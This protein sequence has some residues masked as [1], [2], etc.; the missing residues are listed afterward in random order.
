MLN[1]SVSLGRAGVPVSFIS[2]F[3]QDNVGNLIKD[4]LSI[5]G[6][7][8]AGLSLYN[9]KSPLSL[10]FLDERNDASYEFY[11]DF[12]EKR[13]G[14]N[15]PQFEPEDILVFGSIMSLDPET[16]QGLKN[17]LVSAKNSGTTLYYD[18]NFREVLSSSPEDIRSMI[19]ENIA[20]ADIV[21]ASDEDMRIIG[22]C[23]D[24]DEAYDFVCQRGCDILIYTANSRGVYLRTPSYSGDYTV[25]EI[26]AI[27]TVGAGDSFNAGIAYM[28]HKRKVKDLH[29]VAWWQWDEIIYTAIEFASHVCMSTDNY[30]S[31]EFADMLKK[32]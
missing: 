12:P 5:N 10:A 25:P 3:G 32:I 30:I 8:T 23:T 22:E 17:I 15:P 6:V 28:L 4:F 1:S 16:R 18:P 29:N 26:K 9:G 11:E 27:S 7:S 19:S 2:E 13:L 24:P 20:L 21:R 14:I 31:P